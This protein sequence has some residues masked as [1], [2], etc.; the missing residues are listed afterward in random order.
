M[1]K[2]NPYSG[3]LGEREPVELMRETPRR[4]RELAGRLGQAGLERSLGPGKWPARTILSH[5]ADC[6]IAFAFRL[7]QTLAIDGHLIQPFDQEKWARPYDSMSAQQALE[8]FTAVRGWNLA[9]IK[10]LTAEDL[11]R[12]VSHPERGEMTMNTIL[13]TM[14]GHDNNH[15]E[16]L[17]KIAAQ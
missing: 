6:E 17:K 3:F 8:V 10:T 16:Q 1:T 13:E 11:M 7:R 4:L 15:L 5:L 9:L 14:A 2:V 12:K